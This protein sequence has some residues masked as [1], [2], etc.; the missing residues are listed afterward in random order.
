MATPQIKVKP[1]IFYLD[2]EAENLKSFKAA[3]R[4]NFEILTSSNPKE[5][6]DIIIKN[7]EKISVVLSDQRMPGMT[8]IE[9]FEEVKNLYPEMIRVMVT[10]YSDIN[11]VID[12]INKTQVYKYVQ[13]PWD[14]DYMRTMINQ[15]HEIHTLRKQNKKLT[16]DLLMVNRQLEFM[17]RQKL[18]AFEEKYGNDSLSSKEEIKISRKKASKK[19]TDNKK[20]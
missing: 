14:V 16:D 19:K 15:A 7:N 4:R 18:L 8:G 9:F 3:F 1:V 10:G 2:D 20:K 6:L 17:F 13:K 5:A 11:V 12:A